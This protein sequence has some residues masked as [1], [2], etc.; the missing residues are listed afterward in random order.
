MLPTEPR[1]WETPSIKESEPCGRMGMRNTIN[2]NAMA[3][4]PA[5]N[6]R[7]ANHSMTS[8]PNLPMLRV[9]NSL[10][11]EGLTIRKIAM[12]ATRSYTPINPLMIESTRSTTG[13]EKL[14]TQMPAKNPPST[15]ISR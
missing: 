3:H 8:R 15:K 2:M 6:L 7:A 9:A 11:K 4:S 10:A 12:G 5:N 1:D 13:W 14:A